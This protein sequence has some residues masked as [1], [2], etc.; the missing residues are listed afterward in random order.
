[1]YAWKT[2]FA[3]VFRCFI[4]YS[5][6]ALCHCPGGPLWCLQW[7]MYN[8]PR[9]KKGRTKPGVERKKETA[10]F[11]HCDVFG[12]LY[13]S[14]SVKTTPTEPSFL[15]LA[16]QLYTLPLLTGSLVASSSHVYVVWKD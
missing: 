8:S 5:I 2:K 11:I 10:C 1:M 12:V 16:Q 9:S 6:S 13:S 14:L 15:P 7:V 3:C 4:S